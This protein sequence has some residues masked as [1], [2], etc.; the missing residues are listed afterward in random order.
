MRKPKY[1][2]SLFACKVLDAYERGDLT[3]SN[4]AEWDKAYNGGKTPNPP[5]NTLEIINYYKATGE[6]P[7]PITHNCDT[8][9][10]IGIAIPTPLPGIDNKQI[11]EIMEKCILDIVEG[12]IDKVKDVRFSDDESML[13][14]YSFNILYEIECSAKAVP[15]RIEEFHTTLKHD[16]NRLV[17]YIEQKLHIEDPLDY[18]VDKIR[19]EY[20]SKSDP[21]KKNYV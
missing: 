20:T 17:K 8:L 14:L 4:V 7:R 5:F 1:Y 16:I 15:E 18:H 21:S 2:E 10:S 3:P 12:S 11:I 13:S 19:T 9:L 6:D